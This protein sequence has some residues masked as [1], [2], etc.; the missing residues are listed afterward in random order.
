MRTL[1]FAYKRLD[2]RHQQPGEEL[3]LSE[4]EDSFFESNLVLLGAT[5]VEDKLQEDV[6]KCI[7]DF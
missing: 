4:L 1:A 2:S 6:H 5:G 3:D 7:T